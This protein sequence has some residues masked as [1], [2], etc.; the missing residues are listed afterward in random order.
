MDTL[1]D[2]AIESF[3]GHVEWA[4]ENARWLATGIYDLGSAVGIWD[5]LAGGARLLGSGIEWAADAAGGFFDFLVGGA[6]KSLEL[7]VDLHNV[8]NDLPQAQRVPGISAQDI[9]APDLSTI[10]PDRGDSGGPGGGEPPATP[11]ATSTVQ[12]S[13]VASLPSSA[14][15]AGSPSTTSTR[16]TP[17]T[18]AATSATPSPTAASGAGGTTNN[19]TI[20]NNVTVE[21]A[22]ASDR[23]EM[24]KVARRTYTQMNKRIRK[25][26]GSSA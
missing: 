15:A 25:Q 22:D 17:A 19:Y 1:A 23:V 6:Q 24:R 18:T 20:T 10:G 11:P 16:S 8:L 14:P 21:A 9:D 3:G 7:L 12:T 4:A 5:A 13:A 2:P 26:T